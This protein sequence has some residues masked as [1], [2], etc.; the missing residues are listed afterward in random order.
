ERLPERPRRRAVAAENVRFVAR[1]EAAREEGGLARRDGRAR[2]AGIAPPEPRRRLAPRDESPRDDADL[3]AGRE[4]AE[5]EVV[6]LGPA[7]VAVA[8]RAQD[9]GAHHHRRV[10]DGTLDEGVGAHARG[11]ID[12]IEPAPV[13]AQPGTDA[14][15]R[16][17][18]DAAADGG[19]RRRFGERAEL[20]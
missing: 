8:E 4:H 7:R 18:P 12:R 14:R 19:E 13:R 9:G 5:D 15:A 11:T 10:H 20:E 2:V 17:E 1:E 16:E 3:V 6:V